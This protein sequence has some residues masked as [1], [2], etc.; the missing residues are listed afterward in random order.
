MIS[1]ASETPNKAYVW[2]WLPGETEPVVAGLLTRVGGQIVFNYGRSYL[3]RPD[4]ISLYTPELPLR[5]GALPLPAGL[6]MPS[7]IRDAAP[8]AWGRRVIIN[9]LLGQAGKEADPGVIDELTYM[10]HSGSDRIGALDFQQS[11]TTYVARDERAASLAQMQEAAE[12]VQRGVTLPKAL[13]AAL[14]HGSSI[15][16]ARPKAN[17]T[18]GQTKYIAKFSA[19]A[20]VYSVVKAEFVAMRLASL[21]GLNVAPVRLTQAAG[22][23]VLLIERFDRQWTGERWTRRAMI[24][25]LTILSLDEMM[26]RYASYQDFAEVIRLQFQEPRAT[27]HELYKRLMFNI[28][29]GNTDD[30]ARNHAAF[31]DGH[32]LSL[33]PAYDI[34][35]QGR[36]GNEASQAMLI[37][38][39]DRMSR[40]MSAVDA[41]AQFQLSRQQALE[42]ARLQIEV[43]KTHYSDVCNEAGLSH[44][45]RDLLWRRQILNPF[46]FENAP[47]D[48]VA[49][50]L[51]N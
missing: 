31:W 17:I 40:I 12:L 34:C 46:A 16:G 50:M 1:K 18:D 25:G 41:A 13:D 38:E 9:R 45:D 19:Q 37:I 6:M 24:S 35:P 2:V 42:T 15:G 11:A 7:A 20:D 39:D 27:L 8:D 33:T 5:A 29:V 36:A 28:L 4:A 49:L 48:L 22:K 23:D 3:A 32:A 44:V 51:D 30:H 43:I 10:M 47:A 14:F 21:A 26:A